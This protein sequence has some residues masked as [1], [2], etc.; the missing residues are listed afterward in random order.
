MSTPEAVK[1][2]LAALEEEFSS[3]KASGKLDDQT[4][5]LFQSLLLLVTTVVMLFVEKKTQKTSVNS[6]LPSSKS[7]EDETAK[8]PTTGAKSKGHTTICQVLRGDNHALKY[9][10]NK[11][12]KTASFDACVCLTGG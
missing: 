2:N 12:K 10:K 11:P 1:K 3:L 4:I 5:Q 8:K 9:K 7:G 6:S